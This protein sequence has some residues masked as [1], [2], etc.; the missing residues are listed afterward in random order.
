[1]LVRGCLMERLEARAHL[2]ATALP[3][4]NAAWISDRT[5]LYDRQPGREQNFAVYV[6]NFGDATSGPS[7]IAF[8]LARQ[9][10]RSSDDLLIATRPV[11]LPAG[12][13]PDVTM[14]P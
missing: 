8:Y 3:D 9:P 5:I 7:S 12:Y 14:P 11:D 10:A 4:L 13:A 2:S 6:R 1:M